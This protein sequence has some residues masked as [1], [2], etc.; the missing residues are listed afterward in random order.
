MKVKTS[1]TLSD[2]LL[3]EIDR[4]PGGFRSRSKFLETAARDFL[5]HLSRRERDERDL[6]IINR[7]AKALNAEAEDVLDFQV[8]LSDAANSTA[9]GGG[10]IVIHSCVGGRAGDVDAERFGGIQV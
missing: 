1:I 10:A 8:L 5:K 9:C 3:A 2:D 6:K 7:Q 4:R